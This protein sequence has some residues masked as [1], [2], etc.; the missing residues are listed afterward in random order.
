MHTTYLRIFITIDH[1]RIFL[2]LLTFI[3]LRRVYESL[4]ILFKAYQTVQLMPASSTFAYFF[5]PIHLF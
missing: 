2:L 1:I 4:K 5:A 3:A